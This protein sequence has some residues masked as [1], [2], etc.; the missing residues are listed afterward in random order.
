MYD[1]YNFV[2]DSL[3][4]D[5]MLTNFLKENNISKE[6]ISFVQEVLEEVVSISEHKSYLISNR[7]LKLNLNLE[8]SLIKLLNTKQFG[9]VEKA[10]KLLNFNLL[11]IIH[12]DFY[13]VFE[14]TWKKRF[15]RN[16]QLQKQVKQILDNFPPVE[17]DVEDPETFI[18]YSK[19]KPQEEKCKCTCKHCK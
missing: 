17:E 4:Q 1:Y 7:K 15:S 3:N 8:N 16:M 9:E 14:L 13:Y 18:F 11:K 2:E 5:Q 6:V 10:F 12:N 19:E